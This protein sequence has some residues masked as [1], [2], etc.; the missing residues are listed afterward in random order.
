MN[1]ATPIRA[2]S[3]MNASGRHGTALVVDDEATNR[4]V[5]RSLLQ[6]N[7][8][9]VCLAENGVEAVDMF[10]AVRPDIVF[11]DIMMP[12]M[13]GYEATARIKALC[14]TDF[15]PIIFLTAMTEDEA[16]ARCVEVGGDDFLT[17]PFSNVILKSK[18]QAMERIRDLHRKI[19]TLYGRMQRDEEMAEQVFSGAVHVGN[20]ALN[21]LSTRLQS[22]TTFNGDLML[23]TYGP[24]RDLH[25]LLGDFTGHGLAAALGALPTSE[26][27]RAMT[28]RGFS[29]QQILNAINHKLHNLLPIGFFLAG[30]FVK[31]SLQLD[32]IGICNCGMPD[33]LVLDGKTGVIKHRVVSDHVPLGIQSTMMSH[34][35]FKLLA[36]N[37][38]DRIILA[39]DGVTEAQNPT[40]EM[41]GQERFEAALSNAMVEA[42]PFAIL[43]SML[44]QFCSGAPQTDDISLVEIPCV[45]ELFFE[46]AER[47]CADATASILPQVGLTQ[48]EADEHPSG[49][50]YV[51]T[52]HG[53]HLAK[54]DP[55]PLVLSQIIEFG[56]SDVNREA[57]FTILTELY[58]NALDHGV[59]GVSSSL[60]ASPEGFAEYFAHRERQLAKLQTG[61]VRIA[62][63]V[64]PYPQGGRIVIRVEDSGD[65]FDFQSLLS[66]EDDI[67]TVPYGRGLFIVNQ[68][69]E[70]VRFEGF[71]NKVEAV[72]V[73]PEKS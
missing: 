4:L 24:A 35:P 15:V 8:Y 71:G 45:P 37:R 58:V 60:K 27:F 48:G 32:Y 57:I 53:E 40:G 12:V 10:Q 65:G 63:A 16:L 64:R 52:V 47:A 69:C 31:V 5:L 54:I 28:R 70:S 3:D 66:Q 11:M 42:S 56:K 18:I 50:D 67:S 2:S 19:S 62:V 33:V 21:A 17:K 73:W 20:V 1:V 49:W 22:A 13:N 38:G 23:T 6:K 61:Y 39:S 51:F 72:Y 30:V 14:G 34:D 36:I 44:D 7:G 41:F 68:L 29:P 25:L 43:N 55:V 26:V 59:L 9:D 46:A